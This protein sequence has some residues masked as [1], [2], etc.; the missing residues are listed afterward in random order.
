M[1]RAPRDTAAGL[2]HV[3]IHSVWT[4]E[5][6]HDDVDRIE[7]LRE[8]AATVNDYLIECVFYCL[9]GTHA[10]FIFGVGDGALPAAM[11][12]LNT[13]Y[14]CRFNQRHDLRGHVFSGRYG[15][16][17]IHDDA[18]LEVTFAYDANNPPKAGMCESA[19]GWLWSSYRGTVGL[20]E[21]ASFVDDSRILQLFG[22]RREIAIPRIRAY[23]EGIEPPPGM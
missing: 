18:Q 1:A 9:M 8:L 12:Q 11:Q 4:G 3:T 7:F 22:E 10:H 19:A 13:R 17:R 20:C 5:L 23:V 6:F 15:A 2:F 14:A 16:T 21:Q